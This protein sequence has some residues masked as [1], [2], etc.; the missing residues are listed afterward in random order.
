MHLLHFLCINFDILSGMDTTWQTA[1]LESLWTAAV[2]WPSWNT[3]A[4]LSF[5][6]VNPHKYMESR[7]VEYPLPIG[8]VIMVWY[9]FLKRIISSNASFHKK[10]PTFLTDDSLALFIHAESSMGYW[11]KHTFFANEK[12]LIVFEQLIAILHK[13]ENLMNLT[14]HSYRE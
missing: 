7:L 6:S 3:S 4:W 13:G 8:L 14:I 5:G 10:N 9:H 11:V 1:I 12:P 2:E